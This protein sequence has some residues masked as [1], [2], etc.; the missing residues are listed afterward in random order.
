MLI[1]YLN[2]LD[3]AVQK[4]RLQPGVEHYARCADCV[5]TLETYLAGQL[6]PLKRRGLEIM[7]QLLPVEYDSWLAELSAVRQQ[8]ALSQLARSL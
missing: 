6:E 4:A 3:R 2:D 8:P 5:E 1:K 7:E